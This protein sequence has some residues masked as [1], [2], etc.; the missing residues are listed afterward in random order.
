[1]AIDVCDWCC[2]STFSRLRPRRSSSSFFVPRTNFV[3]ASDQKLV[4]VQVDGA[5]HHGQVAY[6]Q[7]HLVHAAHHQQV[8]AGESVKRWMQES[9]S[10][11]T[12]GSTRA[13]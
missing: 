6:A 13:N 3:Q 5:G 8:D 4:P 7:G 11:G 10:S 12:T 2:C 9:R 1:M